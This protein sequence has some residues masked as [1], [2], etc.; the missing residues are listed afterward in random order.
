MSMGHTLSSAAVI[1]EAK[2]IQEG[3]GGTSKTWWKWSES[4]LGELSEYW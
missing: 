4:W 3:E 2:A 1:T